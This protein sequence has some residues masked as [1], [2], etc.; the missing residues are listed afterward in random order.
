MLQRRSSTPAAAEDMCMPAPAFWGQTGLLRGRRRPPPANPPEESSRTQGVS[1][2]QKDLTQWESW[3][4]L[5]RLWEFLGPRTAKSKKVV[6]ELPQTGAPQGQH[7]WWTEG[8]GLAQKGTGEWQ[9]TEELGWR[10]GNWEEQ[11]SDL[12]PI[13]TNHRKR[14]KQ[15]KPARKT[16]ELAWPVLKEAFSFL[17]FFSPHKWDNQTWSCERTPV[18]HKEGSSQQMTN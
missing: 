8:V 6:C 16:A 7:N 10:L 3:T 15:T 9:W 14:E 17:S 5:K 11:G 13:S 2:P 12:A 18:K 1:S 4:T